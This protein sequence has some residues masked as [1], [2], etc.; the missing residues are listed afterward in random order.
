MSCNKYNEVFEL[1]SQA[2]KI[3]FMSEVDEL[4]Q[5]RTRLKF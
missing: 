5:K 2:V 4:M 3:Y 1:K